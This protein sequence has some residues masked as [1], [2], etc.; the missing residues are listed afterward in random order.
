MLG[1]SPWVSDDKRSLV[2]KLC[3]V[4]QS[5]ELVL[6]HGGRD[7]EVGDG[8]QGRE[9]ICP[10]MS[11][12]I[13]SYQSGAV[14]TEYNVHATN[15]HIVNDI[16]IGS[17]GETGVDV[18]EGDEA[19]AGH[20]SREGHGMSFGYAYIEGPLGHLLHH[21]CHSA[22]CGH[23]RRNSHDAAVHPSQFRECVSEHILIFGWLSA[24]FCVQAFSCLG[25]ISSWGMIERGVL[26]CRFESF[27]LHRV[28][29]QEFGTLHVLY[30]VQCVD[31][32]YDIVPVAWTEISDVHPLEDVLLVGE[33][34][35]QGVVESQ[36]SLSALF[37]QKSPFDHLL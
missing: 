6:I 32:F 24:G 26:F 13:L 18:A 22:S 35:L 34:R 36:Y 7:G 29:V 37:G 21:G 3:R 12:T 1:I 8:T 30:Q 27:S 4:H 28:Y 23:G 16:V 9:I 33:K 20:S 15:S 10:M 25:I 17:L 5:A 19:R 11:G 14:Q 2:G 31:Q